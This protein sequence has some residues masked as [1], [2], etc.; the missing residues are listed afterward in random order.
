MDYLSIDEL[1]GERNRK[2]RYN[3]SA[4]DVGNTSRKHH[5]KKYGLE[6]ATQSGISGLL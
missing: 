2:Q 5:H 1:G 6:F 3:Q 4:A